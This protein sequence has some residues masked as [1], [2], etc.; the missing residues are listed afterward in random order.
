[1]LQETARIQEAVDTQMQSIESHELDKLANVVKHHK[2]KGRKLK[3][4]SLKIRNVGRRNVTGVMELVILGKTRVAST[5]KSE[6]HFAVCFKSKRP[7]NRVER[8]VLIGQIKL[9]RNQTKMVTLLLSRVAMTRVE[10]LTCV[11]EVYLLILEKHVTLWI[12][13]RGRV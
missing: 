11:L 7:K 10:L 6:G 12:V 8:T 9:Q 1:M 4:R 3:E 2:G 5:W 13:L